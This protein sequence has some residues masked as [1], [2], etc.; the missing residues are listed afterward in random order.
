MRVARLPL[1]DKLVI[2]CV[3]FLYH[4]LNTTYSMLCQHCS[5][6]LKETP[7]LDTDGERR[8]YRRCVATIEFDS[9]FASV[10]SAAIEGCYICRAIRRTI[11]SDNVKVPRSVDL[12]LQYNLHMVEDWKTGNS[13][14]YVCSTTGTGFRAVTVLTLSMVQNNG[15]S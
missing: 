2:C 12:R 15:K 3:K 11:L 10:E 7:V 6:I 9:T 1:Q 5:A 13:Q 14:L 4:I 8:S